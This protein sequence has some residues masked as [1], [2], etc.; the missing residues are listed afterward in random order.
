MSSEVEDELVAVGLKHLHQANGPKKQ[1]ERHFGV[2]DT[3]KESIDFRVL[4]K[5]QTLLSVV[6]CSFRSGT[7]L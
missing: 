1:Q 7:V 6:S 3:S 5:M 2:D 4:S